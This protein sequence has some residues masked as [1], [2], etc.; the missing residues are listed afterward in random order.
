MSPCKLFTIQVSPTPVLP[1]PY[2]FS[3]NEHHMHSAPVVLA[4]E[5][6][7]IDVVKTAN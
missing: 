2:D 3:R 4:A 6:Q 1:N 7:A 5:I